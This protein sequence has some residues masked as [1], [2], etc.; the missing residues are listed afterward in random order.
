MTADTQGCLSLPQKSLEKHNI[1]P[2][3]RLVGT[4]RQGDVNCCI[5][6]PLNSLYDRN[7]LF[8]SFLLIQDDVVKSGLNLYQKIMFVHVIMFAHYMFIASETGTIA[9]L[10]PTVC[11]QVNKDHLASI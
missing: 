2:V 6:E 5:Q 1:P 10:K 11:G 8:F 9:C 3:F 4:M 7:N